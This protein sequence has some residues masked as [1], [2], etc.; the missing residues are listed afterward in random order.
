MSLFSKA[1]NKSWKRQHQA[2][3][4]VCQVHGLFLATLWQRNAMLELYIPGMNTHHSRGVNGLSAARASASVEHF[5]RAVRTRWVVVSLRSRRLP[6]IAA[7][8]ACATEVPAVVCASQT[9]LHVAKSEAVAG[10][11]SC[12]RPRLPSALLARRLLRS[13][14]LQSFL[15]EPSAERASLAAGPARCYRQ[16]KGKPYPKSRFCRCGLVQRACSR[17]PRG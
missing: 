6:I 3:T 12:G 7:Q 9:R 13:V 14:L 5:A 1:A 2:K 8:P 15:P 16:I 4:A 10:G 11:P 17:R